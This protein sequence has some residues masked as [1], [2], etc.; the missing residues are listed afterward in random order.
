[1]KLVFNNWLDSPSITLPSSKS[2]SNRALIINALTNN[3][4]TLQGLSNS[5]DTA[6]LQEMLASS[7]MILNAHDCGTAYRF[8]TAYIATQAAG[9]SRI[10]TGAP[11]LRTRPISGL[12]N[13]LQSMGANITYM[14]KENFAPIKVQPT[15]IAIN[16]VNVEASES[17]QFVSALCLVAPSLPNGLSIHL[18][19][20]ISSEPYIHMTLKLMQ[21]LGVESS[22]IDNTIKIPAGNYKPINYSVEADWSSACFIYCALMLATKP[23]DILLQQLSTHSIQGDSYMALL[24][25]DFGITSTSQNENILIANNGKVT[26]ALHYKLD[27]YPDLAIPFIVVCAIKYPSVTISGL[28]TLALKESN[29]II[30]LQTE[31]QK[32]GVQLIYENDEL[33]FEGKLIINKNII[34]STYNDHRIAMALSLVGILNT[35]VQI[36]NPAVVSKSFPKYWEQLLRIGFLINDEQV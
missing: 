17:S 14:D 23:Q 18:N 33:K 4:C 27:S 9:R 15:P 22:Y 29:R 10:I 34:F 31:L 24:A 20:T 3:A 13:A 25:K 21:Q 11:H 2:I 36:E 5:T 12:V 16:E 1:M 35:G 6:T 7:L 30:A 32:V 28:H 8:I 26:P 19:G